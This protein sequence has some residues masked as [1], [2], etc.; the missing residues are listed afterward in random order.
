[1]ESL[2]RT[3]AAVRHK[4]ISRS[5]HQ[6]RA[7]PESGENHFGTHSRKTFCPV[8]PNYNRDCA[9]RLPIIEFSGY[10]AGNSG[11]GCF[12]LERDSPLR[13]SSHNILSN[14]RVASIPPGSGLVLFSHFVGSPIERDTSFW[15][16]RRLQSHSPLS[17]RFPSGA[18]CRRTKTIRTRVMCLFRNL[19]VSMKQ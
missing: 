3:I 16:F 13:L 5:N 9:K 8:R 19:F 18:W 17:T 1:M 10:S 7:R 4:E 11:M 6:H 2:I 15:A 12:P 14:S